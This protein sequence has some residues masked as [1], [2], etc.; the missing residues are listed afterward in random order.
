MILILGCLLSLAFF[1][2]LI[3]RVDV[4]IPLGLIFL[5]IVLRVFYVSLAVYG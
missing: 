2:L 3:E 4:R 5:A 1:L